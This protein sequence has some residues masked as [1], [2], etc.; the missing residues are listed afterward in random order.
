MTIKSLLVKIGADIS[1]L[2]GNLAK[3]D[4]YVRDHAKEIE[5]TV[6]KMSV[7]IVDAAAGSDQAKDAL[8][9]LGLSAQE[10]IALSPDQQFEKIST[11]LAAIENTTI[12]ADT[13]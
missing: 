12:R 3:A 1:E 6:K 9:R 13:A 7:S 10:L 5:K 11:A 8:G 2:Q 4:R